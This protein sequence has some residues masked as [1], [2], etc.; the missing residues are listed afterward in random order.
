VAILAYKC[1]VQDCD[2]AFAVRSNA[3]RHLKTHG[4]PPSSADSHGPQPAY[5]VGFEPPFVTHNY[6]SGGAIPELKWVQTGSAMR[7]AN[8]G[9]D[10][11]S[12]SDE[13][14]GGPVP[15]SPLSAVYPPVD[16]QNQYDGTH[17]Y[18]SKPV[19]SFHN[20]VGSC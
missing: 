12:G 17:P 9:P 5:N 1:P 18:H 20:D 8:D 4:V 15:P 10:S 3:K 11:P 19:G 6:Q 16:G 7:M 14:D 13:V 2:K